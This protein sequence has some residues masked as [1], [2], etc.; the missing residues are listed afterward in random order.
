MSTAPGRARRFPARHTT[1]GKGPAGDHRWRGGDGGDGH[2]AVFVVAWQ[3]P[4]RGG[5]RPVTPAVCGAAAG[6]A[7]HRPG[8]AAGARPRADPRPA[9][10]LRFR[11]SA[12]RRAAALVFAGLVAAGCAAKIAYR[13]G[14]NE[15]RK[16]NWDLAVARLS[17]ALQ[18]DPDNIGYKI[19]LENARVQASRQHYTE[20]RRRLAADDLPK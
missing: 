10:H 11:A 18:R 9:R 13:Q 12:G 17:R 19:T 20:A 6:P 1:N 2:R 7:P 5:S 16:G 8:P 3:R 15:A 14:Q 4:R